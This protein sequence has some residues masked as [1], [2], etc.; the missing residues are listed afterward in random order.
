MTCRRPLRNALGTS[1]NGFAIGNRAI[2]GKPRD[3]RRTGKPVLRA[4]SWHRRRAHR[5]DGRATGRTDAVKPKQGPSIS[6]MEGPCG[7][8]PDTAATVSP[9]RRSP[10]E[11]GHPSAH[12]STWG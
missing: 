12:V 1:N 8:L 6:Y 11:L 5:G 4:G 10:P 3:V 7:I 9:T 2:R